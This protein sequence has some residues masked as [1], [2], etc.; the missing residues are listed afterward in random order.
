MIILNKT[1]NNK[2]KLHG[3]KGHTIFSWGGGTLSQNKNH[4]IFIFFLNNLLVN[5][6]GILFFICL[7]II[8]SVVK[9]IV[10]KFTDSV[11]KCLLNDKW[12]FS[13]L[14]KLLRLAQKEI[15]GRLVM[16]W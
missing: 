2:L 10:F 9:L 1:A 7:N 6:L 5:T 13:V 15:H 8:C 12:F 3:Q 11:P 4:K 14:N 16:F